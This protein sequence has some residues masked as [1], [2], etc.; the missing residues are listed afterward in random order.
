MLRVQLLP[1]VLVVVRVVRHRLLQLGSLVLVHVLNVGKIPLKV[2][3]VHPLGQ[4]RLHLLVSLE[5]GAGPLSVWKLHSLAVCP[6]RLAVCIT[7]QSLETHVLLWSPFLGVT[8]VVALIAV[9]HPVGLGDDKA[10]RLRVVPGVGLRPFA[11]GLVP[12]V[13]LQHRAVV[14]ILT[15]LL[16][17]QTVLTF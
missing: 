13:R 10:S 12:V 11:D 1:S 8:L 2:V 16:A 7:I 5:I 4:I 3:L 14:L 17:S 6:I 9:L 15:V